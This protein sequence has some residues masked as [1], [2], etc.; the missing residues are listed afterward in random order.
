MYAILKTRVEYNPYGPRSHTFDYHDILPEVFEH[1]S[2]AIAYID[3]VIAE[4][5]V[6]CPEYGELIEE[7]K[8]AFAYDVDKHKIKKEDG[9]TY[10][11]IH[12]TYGDAS[13][14]LYRWLEYEVFP[15]FKKRHSIIN[16]S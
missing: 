12:R 8:R 5:E 13:R 16:K 7:D 9:W 14:H 4:D 3:V 15:V 6:K 10:L 1:M 11:A 2:D